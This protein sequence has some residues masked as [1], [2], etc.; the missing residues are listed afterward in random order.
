MVRI[1][2]LTKTVSGRAAMVGV[3]AALVCVAAPLSVNIGAVPLS[4]ATLAVMF[5]GTMLGPG[6]GAAATGIYLLAGA[7]GLPVFAGFNSGVGA[8]AG[9]T[10][11]YLIGYLMLAAVCGLYAL[12]ERKLKSDGAAIA[13]CAALGPLG[14]ALLYVCGTAW[15]CAV[16]GTGAAGAL[17][18]CVLPFLPGDVL[19]IFSCAV[20]TRSVGRRLP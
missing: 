20:L 18:V 1:S 3:H 4:L 12:I 11:G 2:E 8:F 6:K 7:A 14:T 17:S 5:A 9:P 13:A 16:T 19:K 15:F 10:G